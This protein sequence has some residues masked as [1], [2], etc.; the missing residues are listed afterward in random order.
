[1][2]KVVLMLADDTVSLLP[3]RAIVTLQWHSEN[4]GD[5][6]EVLPRLCIRMP[7]ISKVVSKT[8][9]SYRMYKSFTEHFAVP[10][11][12]ED[13]YVAKL[14]RGVSY[15]EACYSRMTVLKHR[16]GIQRVV[17]YADDVVP[18]LYA[19]HYMHAEALAE[20]EPAY[21]VLAVSDVVRRLTGRDAVTRQ[22]AIARLDCR[23]CRVRRTVV[24][25]PRL[26]AVMDRLLGHYA[27]RLPFYPVKVVKQQCEC[28]A[29]KPGIVN[30]TE[31]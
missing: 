7:Y 30:I 24:T 10:T 21:S 27:P 13:E 5:A 17:L 26:K 22:A 14:L 4:A 6:I 18:A 8:I 3:L 9:V 1:M 25:H 20:G 29:K 23:L 31:G 19:Y 15:V 28:M 16:E 11:A 12:D 2:C